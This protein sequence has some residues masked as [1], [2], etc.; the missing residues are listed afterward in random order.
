MAG[1]HHNQRDQVSGEVEDIDFAA[2][3]IQIVLAAQ[4]VDRKEML[5]RFF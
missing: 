4:H 3:A 5:E 2:G 1:R